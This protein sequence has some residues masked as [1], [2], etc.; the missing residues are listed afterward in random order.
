MNKF[1]LASMLMSLAVVSLCMIWSQHREH[2][3][4]QSL[5]NMAL[6]WILNRLS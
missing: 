4:K 2:Y 6:T 3:G 1:M 5:A